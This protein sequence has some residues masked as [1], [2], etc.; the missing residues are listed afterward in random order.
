[1]ICPY[2]N[3]CNLTRQPYENS[4]DEE[5]TEFK[6]KICDVKD[7]FN[8]DVYVCACCKYIT[9]EKCSN[10]KSLK[11]IIIKEWIK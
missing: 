9:H 8:D 11:I 3:K 10:H 1:M 6:C 7:K 2:G 5:I 4:D